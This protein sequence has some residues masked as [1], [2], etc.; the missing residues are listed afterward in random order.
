[1]VYDPSQVSLY[2]TSIY[3]NTKNAKYVSKCTIKWVKHLI[4]NNNSLD[5][6]IKAQ[7]LCIGRSW[8]ALREPCFPWLFSMQGSSIPGQSG[9][10]WPI[11]V[12]IST[13]QPSR[14]LQC[15]LL[16]HWSSW[17]RKI[18]EVYAKPVFQSALALMRDG[19]PWS[20][21][22]CHRL[23]RH[24]YCEANIMTLVSIS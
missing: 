22:S 10:R 2:I 12:L 24:P 16:E 18:Q 11:C 3:L 5:E 9:N 8:Q 17:W 23:V 19:Y 15:M 21:W 4:P 14:S 7:L 1:M 20:L 6:D 13:I